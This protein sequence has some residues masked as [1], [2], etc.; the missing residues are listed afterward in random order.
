M[1]NYLWPKRFFVVCII[2]Y[3]AD[4]LSVKAEAS[5]SEGMAPEWVISEWINSNGLTLAD[6]HK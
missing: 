2:L 3:R 1:G 4:L 6:T 5:S